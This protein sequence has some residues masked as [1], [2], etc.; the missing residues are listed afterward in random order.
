[1]GGDSPSPPR[2]RS[3]SGGG[4]SRSRAGALP[5]VPSHSGL[6]SPSGASEMELDPSLLTPVGLPAPCGSS[7]MD[8]CSSS[9]L[10]AASGFSAPPCSVASLAVLGLEASSSGT[11][12]TSLSSAVPVG[13][14]VSAVMPA[15]GSPPISLPQPSLSPV[16]NIPSILGCPPLLGGSASACPIPPVGPAVV[17]S[18]SPP[19][20]LMDVDVSR[21]G[22]PLTANTSLDGMDHAA[23][24]LASPADSAAPP[25]LLPPVAEPS[26]SAWHG[27][28]RIRFGQLEEVSCFLRPG[29]V[30]SLN[31]DTAREN[32]RRFDSAL[33]GCLLGRRIPFGVVK[34]ELFRQWGPRGLSQISP[35]G[36]DCF[37]C[38]FASMEARTNILLGGPWF[39]AGHIIGID[40][41]SPA[42]SPSNLR[43][44]S[45][46][47]WIRLPNLPLEYWDD[48]NLG[49]LASSIGEPLF[50]DIPTPELSRCNYARICVR[51][52][53]GRPLPLGIWAE[54]LRGRFF[55]PVHYE[56]IP[57]ICSGCGRIGHRSADCPSPPSDL[58]PG[59]GGSCSAPS[60]SADKSPGLIPQPPPQDNSIPPPAHATEAGWTI[61]RRRRPPPGPRTVPSLPPRRGRSGPGIGSS[62]AKAPSPPS[63]G[64]LRSPPCLAAHGRRFALLS[65]VQTL[66]LSSLSSEGGPFSTLSAWVGMFRL[67]FPRR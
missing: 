50:T 61:V 22:P 63:P 27:P 12:S 4:R 37:L 24:S 7:D 46:P 49:R 3:R 18:Q 14:S 56:G 45:S 66:L 10:S 13:V 1:M 65:F 28:N 34:T 44:F 36:N 9:A 67:V 31:L 23:T 32:V 58:S 25:S 33:V 19:I 8:I 39:V 41:W 53:L 38:R 42:L 48:T 5:A 35:L 52:E 64:Y 47:V 29:G 59:S 51:L 55:Q 20:P 16:S 11:H 15:E 62:C 30:I 60:P 40:R 54:G 43:G 2:R 21:V 17:S 57:V 26:K 6:P